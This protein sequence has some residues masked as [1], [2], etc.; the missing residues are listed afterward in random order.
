MMPSSLVDQKK[1]KRGSRADYMMMH[2]SFLVFFLGGLP[3]DCV[4]L[5]VDFTWDC[6]RLAGGC[7]W[8]CGAA[9]CWLDGVDEY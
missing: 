3:D 2:L 7:C 8:V 1:K 4:L 5:A 9:G 6:C